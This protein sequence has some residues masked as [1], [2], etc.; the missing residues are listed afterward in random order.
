MPALTTRLLYTLVLSLSLSLSFP[1]STHVF[2]LF[3]CPSLNNTSAGGH[4]YKLYEGRNTPHSLSRASERARAS[5][6]VRRGELR[7]PPRVR[8]AAMRARASRRARDVV[9]AAAPAAAV[10]SSVVY[11]IVYTPQVC[12]RQQTEEREREREFKR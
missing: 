9:A 3:L 1:L 4:P 12:V 7:E 6:T 2:A 11:N 5:I 10:Y 8:S